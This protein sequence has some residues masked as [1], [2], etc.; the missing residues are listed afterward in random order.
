MAVKREQNAR[1][2]QKHPF[3]SI[4]NTG[5]LV[6]L[7]PYSGEKEVRSALRVWL[8]IIPQKKKTKGCWLTVM[9]II[10][11]QT[12]GLHVIFALLSFIMFSSLCLQRL[13][14]FK[15]KKNWMHCL[16]AGGR[17]FSSI[18]IIKR[19]AGSFCFNS[20]NRC[21]VLY[22]CYLYMCVFIFLWISSRYI[23]W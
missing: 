13:V 23:L 19:N 4:L 9:K 10:N 11:K 12:N 2:Q 14:T 18:F 16:A 7:H 21:V 6:W 17:Y 22:P 20:K 3:I 8:A 15:K 1:L 5:K